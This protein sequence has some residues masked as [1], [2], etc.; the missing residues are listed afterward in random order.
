MHMSGAH[1]VAGGADLAYCA[2]LNGAGNAVIRRYVSSGGA[3]L[4]LCAGAY[5]ACRRVEFEP[6]GPLEVRVTVSETCQLSESHW[7]S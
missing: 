2:Q 7:A 6:G 4:G 3:Y 1:I 5:Y